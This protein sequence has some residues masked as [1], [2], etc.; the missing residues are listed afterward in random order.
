MILVTGPTGFVGRRVVHALRSAD[1]PVR[2]L[3]HTP[4]HAAAIEGS[5]AELLYGDVLD[6]PSVQ[7]AMRDMQGVVHLVAIIREKGDR[8]FQS[9]NHRGTVNI[10]EAAKEAG[11]SRLMHLSAL[12]A[13]DDERF[14]YL[15]SKWQGEQ[16]VIQSGIPYTILRPSIQFGEGD[17]FFNALAAVVKALPLVPVAGSGKTRFQ[18]IAVE[19]VAECVVRALQDTA[20]GNRTVELG[21][22]DQFTYDELMDIVARTLDA[23]AVKVHVPLSGMRLLMALLGVVLP[24]PPATNAMLDMLAIDNTTELD[25]VEKTFSFRPQPVQGN[26]SYIRR[27][28]WSDAVKISAGFMPRHIRDH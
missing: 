25:A 3:V 13:Q 11:V 16:A 1:M 5:D 17:E 24:R 9:V 20:L 10:V 22:P 26:I 27:L 15:R 12:G 6:P 23:S 4:A 14:P 21:G 8:T 28:T 18:P 2:A 19:D 7:A